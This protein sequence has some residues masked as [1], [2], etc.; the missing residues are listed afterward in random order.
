VRGI[1]RQ[2]TKLIR[3]QSSIHSP[4]GLFWSSTIQCG[5]G[6]SVDKR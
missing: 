1:E 5:P 3:P 2:G 6:L 4:R